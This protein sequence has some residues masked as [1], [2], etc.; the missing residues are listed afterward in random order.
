MSWVLMRSLA[1]IMHE[2]ESFVKL[3]ARSLMEPGF[4]IK[5]R[6]LK[7]MT[8]YLLVLPVKRSVLGKKRRWLLSEA[9][10]FGSIVIK[11]P[12]FLL[13]ATPVTR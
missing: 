13:S 6:S 9:L 7:F 5:L 10:V 3:R 8:N 11:S 1:K 4:C 12:W 2:T